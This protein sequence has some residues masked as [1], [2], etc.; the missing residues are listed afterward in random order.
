MLLNKIKR[1]LHSNA[2]K[3]D[4]ILFDFKS[5]FV[6]N[7]FLLTMEYGSSDNSI[8]LLRKQEIFFWDIFFGWLGFG[9]DF[10]WFGL[11]FLMGKIQPLVIKSSI[12]H[13][14]FYKQEI[15]RLEIIYIIFIHNFLLFIKNKLHF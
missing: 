8:Q 14:D 1:V 6:V 2:A 7:P 15:C 13:F 4:S 3:V 12:L 5:G 10:C 9:F 11:V